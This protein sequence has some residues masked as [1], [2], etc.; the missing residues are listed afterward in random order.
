MGIGDV[1]AVAGVPD[2]YYVDTGMF[3]TPEYGAVYIL[4]AERPAIVDA[5][6]GTNYELILEALREVGIAPDDLEVIALTHV[7]LDHA[8]GAGFIAAETGAEVHV[9]ESGSKFLVD[10]D[11]IWEGTKRAVGDQIEHYEKPKPVPATDIEPFHD[12]ATVDLGDRE[13]DVYHAPGHAFHQVLFHERAS[14]AVFV[15]DAAGIY[16]PALD[17]IRET[18]PP[19]GF[20]LEEVVDDAR[21]IA[22]LDPET[23]CYPHFGDV[24]AD[25]RIGEYVDVI[26]RWVEAVAEKRAEL[27]DDEAVIEH[28]VESDDIDEVWGDEKAD[29]EVAMNV[30]G[31]L[32]YLDEREAD[33]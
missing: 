23:L 10:P 24:P 22:R 4:D 6:I 19:P 14:E 26:T 11:G 3:D 29:G 13:L 17:A 18:S 28:F 16:V 8:G 20:T 12:G 7:H 30:R 25:G 32:H 1:S 2:C 27:D 33:E 21:M 9:H 31:V 15:A 5:G